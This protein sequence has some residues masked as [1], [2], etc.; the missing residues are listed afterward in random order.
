MLDKGVMRPSVES[1]Y[2]KLMAFKQTSDM[3]MQLQRR[4]GDDDDD[5]VYYYIG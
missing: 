2:D 5:D 4:P 3:R 1:K